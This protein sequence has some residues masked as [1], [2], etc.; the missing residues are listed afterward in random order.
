[1][2]KPIQTGRKLIADFEPNYK[3]LFYT[4]VHIDHFWTRIS[5][6][7]YLH[8]DMFLADF[9]NFDHLYRFLS[10]GIHQYL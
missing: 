2:L 9:H 4:H 5:L 10:P 6:D 1:M 3:I 7:I 8:I